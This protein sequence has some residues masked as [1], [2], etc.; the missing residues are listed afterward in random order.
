MSTLH[1]SDQELRLAPRAASDEDEVLDE[2]TN[3]ASP[4]GRAFR[5]FGAFFHREVAGARLVREE[6]GDVVVG[7]A[8]ILEAIHDQ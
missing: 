5:S 3:G 8:V 7:E 2:S 1:P 6:D 4:G